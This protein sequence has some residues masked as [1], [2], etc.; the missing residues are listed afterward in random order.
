MHTRETQHPSS[1]PAPGPRGLPLVGVLPRLLRDPLGYTSTLLRQYGD[2]V[3]LNL[4]F[5]QIHL[6]AHPDYAQHILR[7]NHDN[8]DRSL[9][10]EPVRRVFGSG[11]GT[12]E[13]EVWKN[14]RRLLQPI[15]H[16]QYLTALTS[17]MISAAQDALDQWP[18]PQG[19]AQFEIGNGVK[20]VAMTI[21]LRTMFDTD[22]SETE[23]LRLGDVVQLIFDHIGLCI[24]TDYFPSWVPIPGSTRF[25]QAIQTL[26]HTLYRII[27]QRRKNP[28]QERKD[29]LDLLIHARDV[30][31]GEVMDDTQVRDEAVAFF[32]AG[33][34][35]TAIALTWS[36]FLL[37][38][39]PE[40][41]RKLR[42]E[43]NS[44]LGERV[45]TEADIAQ[46]SYAKMVFQ[47]S[48][49][50]YPPGWM[51]LRRA[52]GDDTIGGYHIPANSTLVILTH[53]IHHHAGVW[54]EPLAFVPER[55]LPERIA[56]RHRCAYLP[57]S[58]GPRQ[59]M[60][61]GFALIEGPLVLAMILQRYRMKLVPGHPV[62]PKAALGLY[63]R[64]GVLVTLSPA[65]TSH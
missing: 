51:I 12:C 16:R 29:L 31:T 57:F 24:W 44:V 6:V 1:P 19:Q 63:P 7:D 27:A 42:A 46:L 41:E 49:R 52:K 56:A 5:G 2:C 26:D 59:C 11:M 3:S 22:L 60:G 30:E 36:S 65:G 25:Q 21:M 15:F 4:G 8:Y 38:Q 28:T 33:Y 37:C 18:L 14:K 34:E 48:M 54:E 9:I 23:M 58:A 35:T 40:V 61:S 45:P 17:L 47:E 55:F 43:V 50:L 13:G 10:V 62:V 39:H 32:I 64:K 53:A 20:K